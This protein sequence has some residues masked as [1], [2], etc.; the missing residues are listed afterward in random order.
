MAEVDLSH[1]ARTH[2]LAALAMVEAENGASASSIY[3]LGL[4]TAC[5]EHLVRKL[6]AIEAFGCMSA[7][8]DEILRAEMPEGA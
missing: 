7:T 5:R 2:G 3:A 8:V 1:A 4:M 6:G